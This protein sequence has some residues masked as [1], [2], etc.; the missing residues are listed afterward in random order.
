MLL[1]RAALH[2]LVLQTECSLNLTVYFPEIQ[3][4]ERGSH[5][6]G[7][8]WNFKN[9]TKQS[10]SLQSLSC[11]WSHKIYGPVGFIAVAG[12][13]V[14]PC[15]SPHSSKLWHII[16]SHLFCMVWSVLWVLHSVG[17]VWGGC[18][19]SPAGLSCHSTC[20]GGAAQP[21]CLQE[22]C[23]HSAPCPAEG[24]G[25]YCKRPSLTQVRATRKLLAEK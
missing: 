6:E 20:L 21:V 11:F 7:L 9:K 15:L 14:I 17:C 16:L 19:V 24:T 5:W 2:K 12:I 22:L 18:S 1:Y 23:C 4:Q 13:Q 3:L 25:R 8:L 10:F